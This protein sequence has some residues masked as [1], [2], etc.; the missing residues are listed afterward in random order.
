[1][2]DVAY[3]TGLLGVHP[4][5]PIKVHTSKLSLSVNKLTTLTPA[6]HSLPRLPPHPAQPARIRNPH[7][8]LCA[9]HNDP[10][11]P[12]NGQQT[13]GRHRRI[14]RSRVLDRPADCAEARCCV[15]AC[16]EEGEV[17]GEVRRGGLSEGVWSG[18]CGGLFG[19]GICAELC[20]VLC[21]FVKDILE[22]QAESI[23]PGQTV[24]VIDD[25]IA[26][27]TSV[28]VNPPLCVLS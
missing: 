10:R 15:C 17:A 14:G 4:D 13:S 11:P 18:E 9:P 27:G 16:E 26:T 12:A 5:F 21:C 25:L 28:M 23:Q 8:A 2:A 6:G 7:H 24:V 3:L 20:V 22:M 1:M 19:G